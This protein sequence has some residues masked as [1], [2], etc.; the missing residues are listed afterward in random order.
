MG[1]VA[2]QRTAEKDAV[3]VVA[4]DSDHAGAADQYVAVE[5]SIGANTVSIAAK[6]ERPVQV[7]IIV[8]IGRRIGLVDDDLSA[9]GDPAGDACSNI[10][11]DGAGNAADLDRALVVE[12][13]I[14]VDDDPAGGSS[15]NDAG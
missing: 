15:V 14:V 2:G 8:C 9:D 7:A 5:R 10:D 1:E 11:A 12:L 6:R 3:A 13:V 4:L